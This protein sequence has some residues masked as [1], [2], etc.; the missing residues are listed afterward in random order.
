MYLSKTIPA[1]PIRDIENALQFYRN[2]VGFDVLFSNDNYAVLRRDDA[3]LHLW[4]ANDMKWKFRRF[5]LIRKPI[6]SGAESF[7][8]GTHSCRIKVQGIDELYS[9][10]REKDILHKVHNTIILTNWGT[11]EFHIVDLY[12]NLITFFEYSQ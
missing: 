2:K 11:R 1:F 7:L 12:G 4:K 5:L 8:P 9:E 6:V 3:E 10:L